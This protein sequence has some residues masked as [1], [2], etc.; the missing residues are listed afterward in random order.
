MS[1]HR[2]EIVLGVWLQ[3]MYYSWS[4]ALAPVFHL[5]ST[6]AVECSL[7]AR[8]YASVEDRVVSQGFGNLWVAYTLEGGGQI[9]TPES[10][11]VVLW[12]QEHFIVADAGGQ[13]KFS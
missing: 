10:L 5:L 9:V 7:Y 12:R 11:T 1:K 4:W 8:P 2:Q 13:E 6:S 3:I